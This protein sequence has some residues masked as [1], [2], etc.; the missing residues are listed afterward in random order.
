MITVGKI[1]NR[2][3]ILLITLSVICVIGFIDYD[4]GSELSFSIFYI[5]PISFL[6]LYKGTKANSVLI[7]SAFAVLLCFIADN[8][9]KEYSNLIFSIWNS[10]VRFLMFGTIGLL[11]LYLKEKDKKLRSANSKLQDLNDEKNRIIGI[12]AHDLRN[13]VSGIYSLSEL[14]IDENKNSLQPK[15]LE[16]LNLIKTMSESTLVLLKNLLNVSTI[17]SGKVDLKMECHNYVAFVKDQVMLNQILANHK[18]IQILLDAQPEDIEMN[19]DGHYLS[20]VIGNLLS[21]SIK[22]SYNS[23]EIHI[24]ISLVNGK[25]VLTEVVDEGKGIALEEQQGLFNYFQTTSTKPTISGD[26]S[27]GLGLAIVKKIVTLHQGEIGVKSVLNQGSNFYFTL[28]LS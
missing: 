1:Q 14:L 5:F 22:Y 2:F 23:S 4:T 6:A 18:D 28:P 21:N 13:P 17:E 3:F 9:T 7:A 8:N 20:E 19:F 12:A 15:V 26:R 25:H 10:F 24:H 16:V 27:T 11:L